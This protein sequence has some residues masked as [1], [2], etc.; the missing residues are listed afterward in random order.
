MHGKVFWLGGVAAAS[1]APDRRRSTVLLRAL[2]RKDFVRR[3]RRS[4][5]AR[6][7]A[8][9]VPA[10]AAPRRRVRPDSAARSAPRSTGAPPSGSRR[11]DA[12]DDHAELLAHHYKQA[13][14]LARAA[15]VADDPSLV[16]RAR[17]ALRAAGERALAL[18]PPM[19]SAAEL[20]RRRARALA[21]TTLRSAAAPAAARSRALP[22]RRRRAGLL[23]EALEASGPPVT[24]KVSPRRR[25]SPRAISW[26]AGDRSATD[27]YH[28]R[29]PR[30]RRRPTRDSRAG[31]GAHG[32]DRVPHAGRPRSRSRYA[33]AA[34]AL[35]LVEALGMEEQRARLHI[36]VGCARCCLGDAGGLD[37]IETGIATGG[38]RRAP[39]RASW[40]LGRI[41]RPSSFLRPARGGA[42]R[43]ARE[44]ELAER[45]G[46]GRHL[47]GGARAARLGVPRRALGRSACRRGR[48]DRERRVGR[49]G[50]TATR[51]SSLCAPGSG[52][53]A[54]TR[55]EPTRQRA[56]G[57]PWAR[58]GRAGAVT[59]VLRTRGGRACR[60]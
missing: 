34:E 31:R 16:E 43:V 32:P 12:P 27:R 17:E 13:L 11:S 49:P 39:S 9:R 2:E 41:S 25:R 18:C 55:P 15:G 5:V 59:H 56:G 4:T 40:R 7:H 42:A 57:R 8:V 28:R 50:A 53:H 10:R 52:S 51:R 30:R 47:R 45:Y 23:R 22:A 48:R 20:L 60:R 58:L 19:E 21:R 54:E 24:S 3:E 46:L 35:P 1:G 38:A 44:L 33:S 14:E 37:E 6:R 36:V 26:H 29:G